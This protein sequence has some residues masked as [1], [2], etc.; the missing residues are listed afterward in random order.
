MSLPRDEAGFRALEPRCASPHSAD[1]KRLVEQLALAPPRYKE[2]FMYHTVLWGLSN[3]VRCGLAGGASANTRSQGAMATPVLV[4]AALDG[5][6]RILS[7]LLE[8]GADHSLTDKDGF[9]ALLAAAQEG[10]ADCVQILLDAGAD[11]NQTD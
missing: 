4:Q 7:Q 6:T 2:D 11:S 3:L 8:A 10:H 1:S 9:S 5:N